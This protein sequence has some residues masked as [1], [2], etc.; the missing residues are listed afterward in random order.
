MEEVIAKF[1]KAD[2]LYV[3][4]RR[5]CIFRCRGSTLTLLMLLVYI[6]MRIRYLCRRSNI[7]WTN[8]Y[9]CICCEVNSHPYLDVLAATSRVGRCKLGVTILPPEHFVDDDQS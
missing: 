5:L 7:F 3:I 9:I 1:K 2:T 8:M 4:R 6:L